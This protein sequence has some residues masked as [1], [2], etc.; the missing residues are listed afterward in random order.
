MPYPP[1][2][3]TLA[4]FLSARTTEAAAATMG[5]AEYHAAV[6]AWCAEHGVPP[7]SHR[8]ASRYLLSL[9]HRQHPNRTQGRK[10]IGLAL[11]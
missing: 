11:R 5:N 7:I 1:D 8:R 10:W 3:E 9:G 4:A 2:H 6:A